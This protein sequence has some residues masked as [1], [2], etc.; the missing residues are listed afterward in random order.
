MK[1]TSIVTPNDLAQYADTR[2]SEGVI[3]DLVV[4]LSNNLHPI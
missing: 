4:D 2:E 3:P 1:H